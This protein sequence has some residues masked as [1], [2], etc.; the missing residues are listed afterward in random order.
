M[1]NFCLASGSF[2]IWRNLFF[3]LI[4]AEDSSLEEER[5]E[6]EKAEKYVGEEEEED[7]EAFSSVP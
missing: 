7:E 5:S 3:D 4:E 1:F 6:R 2:E